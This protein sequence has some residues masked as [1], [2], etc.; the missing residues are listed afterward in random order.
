MELPFGKMVDNVMN[1][2]DV[3]LSLMHINKF[4]WT[5]SVAFPHSTVLIKQRN[6]IPCNC[7]LQNMYKY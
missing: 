6:Q 7:L 4:T 2:D 3:I 1:G 5:Y